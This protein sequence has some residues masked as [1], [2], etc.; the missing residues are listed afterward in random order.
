MKRLPVVSKIKLAKYIH[1]NYIIDTQFNMTVYMYAGQL[2]HTIGSMEYR[3]SEHIYI[4]RFTFYSEYASYSLADCKR[5]VN[6]IQIPTFDVI[7]DGLSK[8]AQDFHNNL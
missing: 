8:V 2:T 7:K 4:G 1:E 3:D 5:M 6:Q